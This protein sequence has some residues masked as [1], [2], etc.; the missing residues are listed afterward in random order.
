MP[1]PIEKLGYTI[2][3]AC[4]AIG[5]GRTKLYSEVKN[6]RLKKVK[7]DDRSLI[8]NVPEYVELLKQEAGHASAS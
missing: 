7:V 5:I 3:E 8:V 6:G 4:F 2:N 1:Y